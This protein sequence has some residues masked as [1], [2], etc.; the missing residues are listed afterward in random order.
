MKPVELSYE[1]LV[2]LIPRSR[3]TYPDGASRRAAGAL[4]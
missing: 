4:P 2:F 3:V 1:G